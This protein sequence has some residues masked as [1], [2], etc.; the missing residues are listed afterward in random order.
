MTDREHLLYQN[1]IR[2][3]DAYGFILNAFVNALAEV[4]RPV[5]NVE[6]TP[7]HD[8]GVLAA[9]FEA[10]S[11]EEVDEYI[12]FGRKEKIAREILRTLNSE[13]YNAPRIQELLETFCQIPIGNLHLPTTMTLDIRANLITHFIS[14]HLAF[15]SIA[16]NH[17]NM[18]DI[19]TVIAAS[20]T[21]PSTTGVI[22]G[23]AAGMFL[24]NRVLRP[25]LEAEYPPELDGL[26]EEVQSWYIRSSII[27][28]FI[29]YNQLEECHSLK[30]LEGKEF[31]KQYEKLQQRFMDGDFP[32]STLAKFHEIIAEAGDAPL[33]LRSSS[34]LEDRIG[35]SFTGKY[36]S[37]FIA[38]RGTSGK[39]LQMFTRAIKNVYLSLYSASAIAYRRDNELLDYNEKMSV[40]VQKVVGRAYGKYFFPAVGMVG[41]SHNPYCWNKRIC[42]ED[43][44]LRMVMGLGTRA[45]DRVGD[46]Y[47]RIVSLSAPSLRPEVTEREKIRYSQKYVEVLNLENGELETLHFVDLVN[48]I[49]DQGEQFPINDIVSID[50]GGVLSKPLFR[51][52]KLEYDKCAITF[53]GLLV[54]RKFTRMMQYIFE[55]VEKAYGMPVDLEFAWDDGKLYVLQCRT[56][57]SRPDAPSCAVIVPNLAESQ[58]L[59]RC[60][61]CTRSAELDNIEYAV[62]VDHDAY[63]NLESIEKMQMTSRLVGL[64]NRELSDK[65]YILMGPGRWGSNNPELGVGVK[66]GDINHTSML[67]ELGFE[68]GGSA[69]EL[70][71]GTHFFQDLVEADIIPL[72]LFPEQKGYFLNLE[73]IQKAENSIPEIADFP[74]E[75]KKV[76]KVVNFRDSFGSLLHVKLDGDSGCGCAYIA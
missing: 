12:N 23:K 59:F 7:K 49:W 37:I 41:F 34:F 40:L 72:P 24:S 64:I 10:F 48:Y 29:A 56:L 8:A 4:N 67:I 33:I 43:G 6:N 65:K 75:F 45:V 14:S 3:S 61:N 20:V 11:P 47:P 66:Y 51:P 30:Y 26:I 73:M 36:D 35:C 74:E 60:N 70:S 63:D 54:K 15:L 2:H 50:N 28:E 19:A 68:R 25:T 58:T 39:K 42:K 13:E 16:K 46:D 27:N 31:E 62:Y 22:G 32:E 5:S 55:T 44:M 76:I 52:D 1:I 38:N 17:I 9:A 53:D 69:P 71:Y 57:S 18:R 21:I